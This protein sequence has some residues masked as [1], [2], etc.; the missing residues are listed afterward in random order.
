MGPIAR[1]EPR[2]RP[3][4]DTPRQPAYRARHVPKTRPDRPRSVLRHDKFKPIGV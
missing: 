1:P 3:I 2:P 4:C